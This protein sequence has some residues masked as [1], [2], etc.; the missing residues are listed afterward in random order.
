MLH[1]SGSLSARH[2]I[3]EEP[4]QHDAMLP[5]ILIS[6]PHYTRRNGSTR[7]HIKL[8]EDQQITLDPDQQVVNLK[9]R[10]NVMVYDTIPDE[11]EI[12]NE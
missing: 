5:Q 2:I 9:Y 1:N 10:L 7:L 3:Q 11:Q 12:F 6:R 8:D 4:D